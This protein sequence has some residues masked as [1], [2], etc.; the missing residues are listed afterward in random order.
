MSFLYLHVCFILVSLLLSLF[1]STFRV[2]IERY[3]KT[4]NNR[5]RIKKIYYNITLLAIKIIQFMIYVFCRD[6]D[7]RMKKM[8]IHHFW[9]ENS[10]T[11][12]ERKEGTYQHC[13]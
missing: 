3:N 9:D 2:T 10:Y 12:K 1:S 8:I 6:Y 4:K 13:E 11:H 7:I 5:Q